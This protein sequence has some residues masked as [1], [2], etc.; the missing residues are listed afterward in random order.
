MKAEE[1]SD[2]LVVGHYVHDT[3]ISPAGERHETLGGP[4]AYISSILDGFDASYSVISKVG[5]DFK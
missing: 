3:L 2:I 4:P 5:G 1:R